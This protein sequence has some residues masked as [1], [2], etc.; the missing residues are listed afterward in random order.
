M[1]TLVYIGPNELKIPSL[2]GKLDIYEEN[3]GSFQEN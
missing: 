2:Y 1:V 3:T